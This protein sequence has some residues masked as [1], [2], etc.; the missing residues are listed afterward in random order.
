MRGEMITQLK[1]EFLKLI[2]SRSFFL[3]FIALT[4]FVAL[5]LWGF[6]SYAQRKAG[7]QVTAQFKYTYE[8]KSY[9]NGLTFALYSVTFS[10]SLLIPI[11]VAIIAGAQIAG[12]ANRGTLRMI[13]IRP[14]SRI[15]IF[16]S[17]FLIV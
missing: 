15:S 4:T 6:Y 9:F 16:V 14:V 2:R 17:K 3:S 8:S 13:C 5:M 10:F 11:F 7:E 1:L 12:E